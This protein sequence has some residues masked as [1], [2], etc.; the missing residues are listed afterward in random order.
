M[1]I[2][3]VF[4]CHKGSFTYYVITNGERFRNDY[5]NVIF[6]L[7]NAEFDYRRGRGLETNKKWLRNMWTAPYCCMTVCCD[8]SALSYSRYINL[9]FC[10]STS[11]IYIS[12]Y[13][14]ILRQFTN[15]SVL[16][17]DKICINIILLYHFYVIDIEKLSVR[18]NDIF[19]DHD[20]YLTIRLPERKRLY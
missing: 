3:K 1:V 5:A 9:K 4:K 19:R 10:I 17:L 16:S 12:V 7:S 13:S 15:L 6:A 18:V 20:W 8:F 14:F 2:I 11:Y